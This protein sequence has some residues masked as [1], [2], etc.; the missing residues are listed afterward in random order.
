M[1]NANRSTVTIVNASLTRRV[2]ASRAVSTPVTVTANRSTVTTAS[3]NPTRRVMASRAASS[4]V[5]ANANRSTVTTASVSL[6][7]RANAMPRHR[8]AC[9]RPIAVAICMNRAARK[10]NAAISVTV[11]RPA[12]NR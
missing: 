12:A 3:A 8:A 1:A 4:S 7:R 9:I 5:M 11:A 2:M 10:A 6:I